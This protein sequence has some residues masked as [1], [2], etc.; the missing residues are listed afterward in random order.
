MVSAFY[1]WGKHNAYSVPKK[2]WDKHETCVYFALDN[3]H[4]GESCDW[5]SNNSNGVV[6]VVSHR[7]QGSGWCTILFNS[8][9]YKGKMRNWKDVACKTGGR[10]SW[11]FVKR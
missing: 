1:N 10:S 5:Y 7:P 11:E 2:D 3:M 9:E 6:Q 8:V 4:V